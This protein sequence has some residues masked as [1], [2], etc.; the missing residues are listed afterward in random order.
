MTR[1]E[2]ALAAMNGLLANPRFIECANE[3]AATDNERVEFAARLSLM[4]ADALIAAL[5]TT[6]ASA[7]QEQK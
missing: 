6:P 2:A 4:Y 5:A 7:E 3:A 1:E